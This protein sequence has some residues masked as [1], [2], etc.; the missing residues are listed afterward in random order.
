MAVRRITG[1]VAAVAIAA[2]LLASHTADAQLGPLTAQS[3]ASFNVTLNGTNQTPTYTLALTVSD[4]RATNQA[5]GWKL[6]ITST[7]LSTGGVAPELL[8][9]GASRITSVAQACVSSCS[10]SPTNS[11]TYP[12]AVP[13]GIPEPAAAKFYNAASRTGRG[14]F[15]ITPTIAV[16]VPANA[17]TGAYA[18]TVTTTLAAGP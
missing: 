11:V 6:T 10:V 7:T 16:D 3:T 1:T 2:S 17:L 9:T 4:T 14:T 8:P 12:V 13:A 15:R 18:S 5:N